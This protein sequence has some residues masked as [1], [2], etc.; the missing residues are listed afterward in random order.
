MARRIW[1]LKRVLISAFIVVHLAALTVYNMPTC[2]IRDRALGFAVN[3]MFPLGLWQNWSMFA[4][5]PM[6]NTLTLEA[7]AIDKNGM[8]HNFVFPKMSDFSIWQGVPRVRHSKFTSY[9]ANDEFAVLREVGARHVIRELKIPPEA[10]PVEVELRFVVRDT[11]PP[12]T[13]PD[14]MALTRT[15]PI[16]EYLFPNW[17]EARP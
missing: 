5:N 8:M 10:F 7:L 14:P 15:V 2:V 13:V 11:P 1:G 17:E 16:K 9:F 3:Y 6:Q 4:P 12:G